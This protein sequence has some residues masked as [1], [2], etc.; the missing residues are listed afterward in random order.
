MQHLLASGPGDSLSTAV[1]SLIS[2]S[3]PETSVATR[4]VF[5]FGVLTV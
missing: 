1:K 3:V 5:Y 4:I 2:A